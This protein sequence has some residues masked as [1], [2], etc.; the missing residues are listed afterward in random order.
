MRKAASSC[1][2]LRLRVEE[3]AMETDAAPDPSRDTSALWSQFHRPLAAYFARR[4]SQPSDVDDL[5]Q[6]V[7]LR[8]HTHIDALGA[9]HS[10]AGWIF[11]TARN[12]LI[13][14]VRDRTRRLGHHV[15]VDDLDLAAAVDP[16][17]P[18]ADMAP[19]VAPMLARLPEAYR[20][21]LRL[22]ELEGVTQ[23]AAAERAGLSLPGM[24]SRIQRGRARLR[25]LL[26]SSCGIEVDARGRILDFECRRGGGARGRRAPASL[27]GPAG[28][29]GRPLA[30]QCAISCTT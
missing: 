7:F 14:L 2:S 3:G 17:D 24:K 6:E 18:A 27:R 4:V 30:G 20:E 23:A 15:A 19:C 29:R 25:D 21:G 5:L 8:V 1:G 12:V 16:E 22:T 10:A 11:R 9:S 26:L 13:D 28:R